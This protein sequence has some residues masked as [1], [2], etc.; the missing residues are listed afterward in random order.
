M[1]CKMEYRC[2]ECAESH[3]PGNCI[4]PKKEENTQKFVVENPDGSKSTQIGL[5]VKCANCEGPHVASFRSCPVR[6]KIMEEKKTVS[7][8]TQ[9]PRPPTT[10]RNNNISYSSIVST[11]SINQPK[12]NIEEETRK[13]FGKNLNNCLNRITNFTPN[14]TKLDTDENKKSSLFNLLFDLCLN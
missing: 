7:T 1:N 14:Y 2:V 9:Q 10:F 11:S 13:Y 8:L 4:I 5:K 6:M 3:G 12:L